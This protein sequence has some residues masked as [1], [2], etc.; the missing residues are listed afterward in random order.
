MS[1]IPPMG[2]SNPQ[3]RDALKRLS[4]AKYGR[5]RAQV[6]KEIFARLG[7]GDAAKRAKMEAMK[8]AQQQRMA[9]SA[10]KTGATGSSFLDDWLAKRQ[11]MSG[12]SAS[13]SRSAQPPLQQNP[14]QAPVVA[15]PAPSGQSGHHSPVRPSAA[16]INS[17]AATPAVAPQGAPD[18]KQSV[19]SD[20][21]H[22]RGEHA[23]HGD[24]ISIK[25]R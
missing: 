24:E 19:S 18:P 7:A 16:P 8:K 14:P 20:K 12:G 21:L 23:S 17:P 6:E 22:L 3:L 5:P 10:P 2:K 1:L 4:A 9:G 15:P 11:Q 25:I 13:A